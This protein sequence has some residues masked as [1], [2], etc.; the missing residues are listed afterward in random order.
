MKKMIKIQAAAL[1]VCLT[2]TMI[3]LCTAQAADGSHAAMQPAVQTKASVKTG[4]RQQKRKIKQNAA[5]RVHV[6]FTNLRARVTWTRAKEKQAGA[7]L[8]AYEI[9][10]KT[11]RSGAMKRIARV[12]AG[13]TAYTDV[14]AQGLNAREKKSLNILKGHFLDPASNAL[15][16]YVK[17]VYRAAGGKLTAGSWQKDGDFHLEAPDIVRQH[18]SGSKAILYWGTV[19]NAE[20]YLIYM[21]RKSGNR[22]IWSR[23][24]K[25]KASSRT[26]QYKTF[27]KVPGCTYYTV[28]AYAKK[29]GKTVFSS[30][31][32]GFQTANK[33]KY[34]EKI[35]YIGDSITHGTPYLSAKTQ[36]YFSYPERVAQLTGA[37]YYN[38]AV[39]GATYIYRKDNSRGIT[40]IVTE[41]TAPLAEGMTPAKSERLGSD[42]NDTSLS[43]YDVIVLAAGTNDYTG[44]ARLGGIRSSSIGAF[45]GALNRIRSQIETASKYR[46]RHGKPAIKVVF[47]DLFYSNRFGNQYSRIINRDTAANGLGLTLHDYQRALDRQAKAW[48]QSSCLKV[49]Q[50]HTRSYGIVTGSTCGYRTAD[51]L[52]M[53]KFTY[54][55]YG[56]RLAEFLMGE[57]LNRQE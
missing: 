33:G 45:H 43:D 42:Y 40:R 39:P 20:G 38:P 47:V 34:S 1:A 16:Y 10:R 21:G 57:V 24:A 31:D 2:G 22:M 26:I 4:R 18:A 7:K 6:D 11:S 30:Y 49:Y 50:F 13:K 8:Y 12:K 37:K 17:P 56:N 44:S 27:S 14:Y 29:N 46:M 15:R 35:L 53:T 41:V 51:N 28:R 32:T 48:S 23:T 54:G 52:H 25:V 3:P 19:P 55:Q 36:Q 5:P 9:Y